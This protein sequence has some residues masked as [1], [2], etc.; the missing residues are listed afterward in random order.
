M[1]QILGLSG[2]ILLA[3]FYLNDLGFW[4]FKQS[5]LSFYLLDY[6]CRVFVLAVIALG[7]VQ[8]KWTV[9]LFGLG[10]HPWRPFAAWALGLSVLGLMIDQGFDHIIGTSL[11]FTALFKFPN[12]DSL[13]LKV[14]DQS[15]GILLVALSEEIVFR[16]FLQ[17]K[18]SA[19]MPGGRAV[20]I[21]TLAFALIHWGSG[22]KPTLVSW[23]WSLPP[24]FAVLVTRSVWPG[25]VAH[26]VTDFIAFW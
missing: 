4:V 3:P 20:L 10:R 26:F 15:V 7:L 23:V 8:Q 24:T 1:T 14:F 12:P 13:V 16:G 11:A 19:S 17:Q 5:P 22:L 25:V 6:S 9:S 2:M 21:Q 18:L